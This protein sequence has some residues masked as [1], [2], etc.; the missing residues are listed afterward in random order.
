MGRTSDIA[1]EPPVASAPGVVRAKEDRTYLGY[2]AAALAT[3]LGG[4]FVF[5]VWIPLASTGTVPG[6]ERLPWM[7]QA[8]GWVMLQGWTGLFVAGMAIR[9]IP[10]FA[11]RKPV[12][13][14]I[15]LPLLV[16]LI[17][18]IVLR[19][20]FETWASGSTADAVAIAIGISSAGG[21]LGVSTV[22][23]I[24]LAKG[25]KTRDPWRYFA[26]AGT[27]WWAV[28]AVLSLASIPTGGVT[29]GLIPEQ[30]NQILL[31]VVMLGPIANFIWGVQSRSVPVFYG[32]GTPALRKVAAPG[33]AFNLGVA[34]LVISLFDN[35]TGYRWVGP[36][37][38]LVGASLVWLPVFAGSVHGEAK[39][40]RPRARSA[41]RFLIA[42]NIS[43]MLAGILL[44][45]VGF[46]VFSGERYGP[47]GAF[48]QRDAA[49]H[50]F[51]LGTIS[52]LILGMARLVA[53]FFAIERTES[54]VP[55]FLEHLPLWFLI[56]AVVLR[57]GVPLLGDN[58]DRDAGLHVM[59]TAGSLAWAAIA[60]FAFSVARAIRAE[61]KSK[62]ALEV[63]YEKIKKANS[64][65]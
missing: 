58:L 54:G 55:N 18:P 59:A 47:L 7:I 22:L 37:F 14:R 30:D 5:A 65:P 10:R 64:A 16:L 6:G 53:P 46:V 38:V 52:M 56:S 26:W 29:A 60:I 21:Q 40:L 11:G 8:H 24:T 61:P 31:W 4:S 35:A 34:L 41:A 49:R 25:R 33:I 44:V 42:A 20:V 32:R 45:W 36:G 17:F 19:I 1:I 2:I 62:R 13:R 27:I 51:G 50:L 3:A 23:A 15:T 63:S 9:L 28:W 39:R 48:D 12:G 43:A 57:A